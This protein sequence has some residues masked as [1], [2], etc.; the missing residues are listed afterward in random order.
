MNREN[1][2]R[3]LRPRHIAYIGG[4]SS[5]PGIEGA[6]AG[7]FDGPV[8]SVNPK[9]R[10]IAGLPCFASVADLPE[11]PDASFIWVP[12]EAT[13][14]TVRELAA[15]GAGGAVCYAAGFAEVDGG[16]D[17]QERL[18]EAAGDFAAMGPNCHVAVNIASQ[19]RNAVMTGDL[20]HSPVQLAHPEWSPNFDFEYKPTTSTT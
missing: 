7:G 15:V 20:M 14:E 9:R 18:V 2:K 6:L 17:H 1:L 13:I 19:G 12:R 8:W 4:E 16:A 10:S 5:A 3:L 11:P